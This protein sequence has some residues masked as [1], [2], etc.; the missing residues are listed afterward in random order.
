MSLETAIAA[1]TKAIEQQSRLVEKNTN[2]LAELTRGL[3]GQIATRNL[4]SEGSPQARE[5]AAQQAAEEAVEAA[6]ETSLNDDIVED[7]IND[8]ELEDQPEQTAVS[9][10]QAMA[11]LKALREATKSADSIVALL[12]K[13][14]A[15]K[16]SELDAKH[17]A[18]ALADAEA[19]MKAAS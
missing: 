18:D 2:H 11:A 12:A 13:Y 7:A 8:A 19:Q 3:S 17:Y 9:K 4:P 1:L 6:E 14:N 5:E 10:E 16:F 15:T